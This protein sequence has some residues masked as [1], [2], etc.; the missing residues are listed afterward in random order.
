MP[1]SKV[2]KS[3]TGRQEVASRSC[4]VNSQIGRTLAGAGVGSALTYVPGQIY[5]AG[6]YEGDPLRVISVT[7]AV[8]GP[9]DAGTVVVRFGLARAPRDRRS[10][11]RRGR[12]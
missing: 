9:F 3:K 12:I 8:A 2:A 6:L 4:P 10:R 7:S 1:R 5:F 11:S